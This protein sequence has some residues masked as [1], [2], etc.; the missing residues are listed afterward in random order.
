MKS[1]KIISIWLLVFLLAGV[2]GPWRISAQQEDAAVPIIKLHYF[3]S[4]NSI[5]YLVL[6][7]KLKKGKVFTPQANKTYQIYLDSS[8]AGYLIAIVKTDAEGKAKTFVPPALQKLWEA[9]PTHTFIV[10]AGDEEIITDYAITKSKISLDTLNVDGTRSLV[11]SVQKLENGAWMPAKDIELKIGVERMNSILSAGDEGT[12]TTDSTG[13]V[14]V[15]LKKLLLPGDQKGNLVLAVK[16]EDQD[17]IGNL[18][19]E[20]S[21]AWGKPTQQNNHFFE[22]RTLWTTRFR[23]PYWLLFVVYSIAIGVWSTL[24][25]LVF[26]IIKIRKLGRV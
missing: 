10:K 12:Y 18:L 4:N 1:I 19:I 8:I 26:Q 16:A 23:T 11:A 24:I 25:Y 3:N 7:S 5:Q 2:V 13:T 15:E 22:L 14:T 17:Q 21:V 6:D 20:R 9:K